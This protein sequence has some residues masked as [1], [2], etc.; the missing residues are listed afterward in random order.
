MNVEVRKA[1]DSDSDDIYAWRNDA[2]T[3]AM[4][5]NNTTVSIEDHEKWFKE[6]MKNSHRTLYIGENEHFKIGVCRFDYNQKDQTSTVSINLNP[7][8]RGHGFSIP[9]LKKSITLFQKQHQSELCATIR[10]D[11][12]PSIKCFEKCGFEFFSADDEYNY[13]RLSYGS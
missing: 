7:R 11:N 4:S 1:K 3:C 6:S 2:K 8:A 13:Y 10:K 9:F 5:V 12:I